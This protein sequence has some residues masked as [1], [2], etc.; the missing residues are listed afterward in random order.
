MLGTANRGQ[1]HR[2]S[3]GI[4]EWP[5]V[6]VPDFLTPSRRGNRVLDRDEFPKELLAKVAARLVTVLWE[7]LS[8]T[9]VHDVDEAVEFVTHLGQ[10]V[11]GPRKGVADLGDLLVVRDEAL[12]LYALQLALPALDVSRDN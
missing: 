6:A 10:F 8:D 5:L 2:R 7:R 9:P 12:G 4:Q 11:A 3:T 1:W